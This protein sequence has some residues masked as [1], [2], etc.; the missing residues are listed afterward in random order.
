[1]GTEYVILNLGQ[2]NAEPTAT[3]SGGGVGYL[4]VV[5]DMNAFNLT[6]DPS[7]SAY[8][9]WSVETIRFLTF[10]NPEGSAALPGGAAPAPFDSLTYA[11]YCKWLPWTI[12]EGAVLNLNPAGFRYPNAYSMPLGPLGTAYGSPSL[13]NSVVDL[14][15]RMQGHLKKRI[16]VISLAI[17]S[18]QLQFMETALAGLTAWGWFDP[19]IHNNWSPSDANGLFARLRLMLEAAK[20]AAT[21]EGNTLRVILVTMKQGETD[22]TKETARNLF[23]TNAKGFVDAVRA[24]LYE[25]DLC[26]GTAD[27]VPFVWPK[28][29]SYPWGATNVEPINSALAQMHRDDPY[30]ATY[31]TDGFEKNSGDP[32]HYSVSGIMSLAEADFE[33]FR[34]IRIRTT[35][36]MPLA[37]V[38]TFSELRTMIRRITERNTS[39]SGQD[40]DVLNDAINDAYMDIVQFVGDTCWWLRQM[41][42]HSLVAGPLTQAEMPRVVTRLLEIRPVAAPWAVIDWSMVGHTDNGRVKIVTLDYVSETVVLHHIYQPRKMLADDEK[43][44][45]PLEYVEALKVGAARRVASASGNAQ[46]EQKLRAEEQ[47]LIGLVSI[48][49][50]K[51]DRQR[52]MRLT[53]RRTERYRTGRWSSWGGNYPWTDG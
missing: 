10:Y 30:F 26:E 4:D 49:A 7:I 12:W 14:A 3:V 37:D 41:T 9:G 38:P 1:M 39:D 11:S 18:S 24:L 47:R 27:Q 52:R 45:L 28:I 6:P 32:L 29:P 36:S 34:A 8:Y 5:P 16:N 42:T 25:L 22:S 2:S 51:V 13:V 40:D 19:R 15:R 44:V 35:L 31:E 48:H 33:A 43:P 20:I 46:L 50:N 21:A 23:A 53:G 17:R